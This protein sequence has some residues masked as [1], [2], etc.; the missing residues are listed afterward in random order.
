MAADLVLYDIHQP[1][2]AGVHTPLLA[3]LMCG[4][5]VS[6]KY[7]FVQGKPAIID[8]NI[9]GLDEAELTARVQESVQQLL[10]A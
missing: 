3:P 5:P 6:I 10:R 8:G 1:R 7:S 4:E 9:Q 2:F